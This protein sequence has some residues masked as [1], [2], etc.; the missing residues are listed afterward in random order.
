[1]DRIADLVCSAPLLPRSRELRI[2]TEVGMLRSLSQWYS[3]VAA[4]GSAELKDYFDGIAEFIEPHYLE[5]EEVESELSLQGLDKIEMTVSG[6]PEDPKID[7]QA[8]IDAREKEREHAREKIDRE[9]GC[10][11]VNACVASALS[12]HSNPCD[13]LRNMAH[14]KLAHDLKYIRSGS[15]INEQSFI[16]TANAN[17]TVY[18]IACRGTVD[19]K[20]VLAD[21]NAIALPQMEGGL[22]HRGFLSR[23]S[24]IPVRAIAELLDRGKRVVITGHSL[25][26][27]VAAVVTTLLLRREVL[28]PELHEHL[29]CITIASPL[30]CDKDFA[31]NMC[32]PGFGRHFH[33]VVA[34]DDI[35]PVALQLVHCSLTHNEN[36][37]ALIMKLWEGLWE[38]G[39]VGLQAITPGGEAMK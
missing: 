31:S 30:F 39:I 15:K 36:T 18:Y 29:R 35:V 5:S 10:E 25:G 8:E 9:L 20:D 3:S 16:I 23:A 32:K 22:L 4:D 33:H 17:E 12:Y 6:P 24:T 27:A 28:C 19:M 11:M 34:Q 1:M 26:G 7:N 14:H 21:I 38:A 37:R 2:P 13:G